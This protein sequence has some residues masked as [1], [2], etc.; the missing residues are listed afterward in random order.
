LLTAARAALFH[1]SIQRGMP[2]LVL[3]PELVAERVA[4][5]PADVAGLRRAVE[6][7]TAYR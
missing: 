4:A 5:D 2:E 7:L 3:S 6:R 1:E